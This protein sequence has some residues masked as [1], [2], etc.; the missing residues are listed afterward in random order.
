MEGTSKRKR[1]I[2]IKAGASREEQRAGLD[3]LLTMS[4]RAKDDGSPPD[5]TPHVMNLAEYFLIVDETSMPP[6]HLWAD[7]LTYYKHPHLNREEQRIL[8]KVFS[9]DS[10]RENLSSS[11]PPVPVSVPMTAAKTTTPSATRLR[12]DSNY[13]SAA[14]KQPFTYQQEVAVP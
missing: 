11:Q 6:A 9:A 13:N 10:F 3:L 5:I 12:V 1:Q 2:Y 8:I 7:F 4:C 14:E